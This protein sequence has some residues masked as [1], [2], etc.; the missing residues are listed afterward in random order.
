M[1][2]ESDGVSSSQPLIHFVREVDPVA[3]TFGLKNLKSEGV[4]SS[5]RPISML[6]ITDNKR[7]PFGLPKDGRTDR[8]TQRS[9]TIYPHFEEGIQTNP[10]VVYVN[11]Y[12]MTILSNK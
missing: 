6:N 11:T 10:L 5:Q 12:S 9:K 8:P 2:Y 7:K 1:K 4:M 3:V